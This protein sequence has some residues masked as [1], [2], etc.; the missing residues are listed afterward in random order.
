[1][2]KPELARFEIYY[3]YFSIPHTLKAI[4]TLNNGFWTRSR[5]L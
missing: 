3:N 5:G 2:V 4:T 1:M